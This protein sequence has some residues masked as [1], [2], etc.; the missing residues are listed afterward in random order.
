MKDIDE[1]NRNNKIIEKI[2]HN[3]FLKNI[4]KKNSFRNHFFSKKEKTNIKN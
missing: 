1:K 2:S 4:Q 3:L